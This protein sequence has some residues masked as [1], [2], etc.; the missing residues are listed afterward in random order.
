M[1]GPLDHADRRALKRGISLPDGHTFIRWPRRF[2][3]LISPDGRGIAARG[4]GQDSREAFHTFLL[5]QAL[6]YALIR[7]RVE[8]LH[9]TVMEVDGAAVAFLGDSGYGKSSL[10]AALLAGGFRLLTDDLLVVTPNGAGFVAHPGPPRIKLYP[11]IARR[12]LGSKVRGKRIVRGEPKLVIPLD[13]KQ[14]A[15]EATH[16]RAL[17]IIAPGGR[18]R[19]TDRI[20]IR[21]LSARASCVELL[22]STFNTAVTDPDRLARQFQQA[23]SLAS[24]LPVRLISYPRRLALL[25]RVCNA[26][27]SDLA[28]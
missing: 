12:F 7:Q 8:P 3:F 17:Y 5:G 22:R 1:A 14:V 10:A 11:R 15:G 4:L 23:T 21:R 16:L 26:I 25:P 27:L 20:M 18:A 28:R 9:A 13:G 24:R 19:A 6:S 2:E